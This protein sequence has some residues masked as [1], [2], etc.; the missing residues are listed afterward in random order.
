MLGTILL[1]AAVVLAVI[2]LLS[3]AFV[4][5][6]RMKYRPVLDRVRRLNRWFTNP[7]QL[8]TAGRP[9]TSAS[10]VH[11]VGRTSGRSY[12]T[13][14]AVAPTE[15]GLVIALP[16]GR[17][18]DWV[19]NV[20]AAGG[21]TIEHEGRSVRVDRPEFVPMAEANPR[22]PK[23]S[24]RTHRRFGVKDFLALRASAV[25]AVTAGAV[26]RARR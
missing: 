11:H 6:F 22:F 1:V 13:P 25:T 21:A 17:Q 26:D 20:V 5:S 15:D 2:G 9:G 18:A 12:R 8:R 14:V 7:R 19:R 16:Y 24:Q 3:L 4:L 10:V 23:G